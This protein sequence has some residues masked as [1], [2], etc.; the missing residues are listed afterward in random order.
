MHLATVKLFGPSHA[1]LLAGV[2]AGVSSVLRAKVPMQVMAV[3]CKFPLLDVSSY[4]DGGACSLHSRLKDFAWEFV[5]FDF[6]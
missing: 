6:A 5:C 4:I 2:L 3:S 1:L